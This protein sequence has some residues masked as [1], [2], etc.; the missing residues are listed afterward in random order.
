MNKKK[1]ENNILVLF[2]KNGRKHT[3]AFP[4]FRN[5]LE[6]LRMVTD[7]KNGIKLDH[8]E[9]T[10]WIPQSK[11]SPAAFDESLNTKT[12]QI[13]L[14]LEKINERLP[15][16]RKERDLM[17]QKLDIEFL[18]ILE[19]DEPCAECK[20]HLVDIK[21]YLRKAPN[22]FAQHKF[23]NLRELEYFNIFDNIFDIFVIEA[24]SGY[25]STPTVTVDKP[26]NHPAFKGFAL[27]AEAVVENGLIKEIKVTQVGSSYI[28]PPNV[29]ISPPDEE[30]GTQATARTSLVE[31]NGEASERVLNNLKLTV[32]IINKQKNV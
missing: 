32:P 27:E 31:N 26:N 2:L 23:K 15:I 6:A 12:G 9:K 17:L 7:E 13:D 19:E 8:I 1:V 14:K 11:Y 30:G 20:K 28:V 4:A 22:L 25:L 5:K 24:G 3:F 21:K 16:I 29:I 10:Y 18:K